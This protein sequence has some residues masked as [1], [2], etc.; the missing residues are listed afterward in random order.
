MAE[1]P[2]TPPWTDTRATRA[3]LIADGWKSPDTYCNFFQEITDLSAIY[4]FLL[5]DD[6]FE[7]GLVSYVGMSKN[8]KGRMNGHE[9]LRE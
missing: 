2:N 4:L 6:S 5:L 7:R 8:L 1:F 3:L 9:I